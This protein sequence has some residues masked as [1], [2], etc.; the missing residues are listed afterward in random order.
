ME[1]YI[2]Q[3]PKET[4]WALDMKKGME[5]FNGRLKKRGVLVEDSPKD[6]ELVYV[7]WFDEPE[8]IHIMS[9]WSVGIVGKRER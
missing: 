5:V 9:K 4:F 1:N 3:P 7:R 8:Q 6:K 2:Y